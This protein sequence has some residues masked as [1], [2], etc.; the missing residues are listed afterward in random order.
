MVAKS[1]SIES[2]GVSGR[3]VRPVAPG[4][5][6]DVSRRGGGEPSSVPL[7][8]TFCNATGRGALRKSSVELKGQLTK[9][10]TDL[11]S[12]VV[13]SRRNDV[14]WVARQAV[15]KLLQDLFVGFR[16]HLMMTWM[17][18]NMGLSCIRQHNS[19]FSHNINSKDDELHLVKTNKCS[20][21]HHPTE[22]RLCT[23]G[24]FLTEPYHFEFRL[25]EGGYSTSFAI[26][27][28]T[29]KTTQVKSKLG[30]QWD[31]GWRDIVHADL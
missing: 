31:L 16:W 28:Q 13:S 17:N 23:S 2:T 27:V 8:F 7:S 11:L 4:S 25:L 19:G 20:S 18:K 5:W 12:F 15:R 22:G 14:A 29:K 24:K 26:V 21:S 9:N 10:E 30:L 3:A 1:L 6:M